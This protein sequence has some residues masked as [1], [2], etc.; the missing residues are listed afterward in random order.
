[1]VNDNSHKFKQNNIDVY[2]RQT[3]KWMLSLQDPS[4]RLT[5]WALR[6]SEFDYK[7]IHKPGK[8]HIN[9]HSRCVNMIVIPF[10]LRQDEAYNQQREPFCLDHTKNPSDKYQFDNER[11]LYNIKL[12]RNPRLVVAKALIKQV[13]SISMIVVFGHQGII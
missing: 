4:S 13:L 3:L 11:L 12:S 7:V 9:A 5:R 10:I 1:M 8:K 6:L 2:K